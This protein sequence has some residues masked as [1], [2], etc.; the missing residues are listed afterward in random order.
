MGY[1][2]VFPLGFTQFFP[3][4]NLLTNVNFLFEIQTILNN[5]MSGNVDI[6]IEDDAGCAGCS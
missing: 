5:I 2:V 4:I 3:Q 6:I 1:F